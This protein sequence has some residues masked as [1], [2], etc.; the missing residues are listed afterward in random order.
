MSSKWLVNKIGFQKVRDLLNSGKQMKIS[1]IY[2]AEAAV[3]RCFSKYVLQN[4]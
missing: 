4:I 2:Y 1:E 3:R